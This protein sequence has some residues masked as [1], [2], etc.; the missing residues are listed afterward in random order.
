MLEVRLHQ[1]RAEWD[2]PFP[3][4]LAVLSLMYPKGLAFLA[5]KTHC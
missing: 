5:A 4:R 1:H 2:N 3:D